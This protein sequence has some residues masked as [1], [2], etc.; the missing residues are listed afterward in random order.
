MSARV[1]GY[2]R[3]SRH[4]RMWAQQ[5]VG[6]VRIMTVMAAQIMLCSHL[7]SELSDLPS[8]EDL[9]VPTRHTRGEG[10]PR[11]IPFPSP[12]TSRLV[13]LPL[14]ALVVR[15]S[16]GAML[17][18]SD[19]GATTRQLWQSAGLGVAVV[20]IATCRIE[21]ATVATNSARCVPVG[22]QHTC[23]VLPSSV[24]IFRRAS[25][26]LCWW[27][28]GGYL[29]SGVS[30]HDLVAYMQ[31]RHTRQSQATMKSSVTRGASSPRKI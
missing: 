28:E 25:S 6:F 27:E 2:V 19:A 12:L 22:P 13:G 7:V 31:S 8:M 15:A 10:S 1:R 3:R 23:A 4:C 5:L 17:A 20:G 29:P 11:G 16:E 30:D 9:E 18:S 14:C 26:A 24:L 21:I